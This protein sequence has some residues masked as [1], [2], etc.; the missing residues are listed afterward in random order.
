ME[1]N[2]HR[3]LS[4]MIWSA[5]GFFSLDW[6]YY[7]VKTFTLKLRSADLFLEYLSSLGRVFICLNF[8]GIFWAPLVVESWMVILCKSYETLML[9][10]HHHLL[11]P[12]KH[13]SNPCSFPV[14]YDGSSEPRSCCSSIVAGTKDCSRFLSE[15]FIDRRGR[16]DNLS[17]A[18]VHLPGFAHTCPVDDWPGSSWW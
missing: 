3:G 4:V 5:R 9:C 18:G 16:K 8:G 10:A 6:W 13:L 12:V 1:E 17:G 7:R 15:L 2:M 11:R 14:A